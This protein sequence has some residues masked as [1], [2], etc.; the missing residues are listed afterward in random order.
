MRK[1]DSNKQSV[2]QKASKPAPIQSSP[3][4]VQMGFL[5]EFAENASASLPQ[6]LSASQV[7][8]L[9]RTLGNRTTTRLIQ[10]QR[11]R[12]SRNQP[13]S[14]PIRP[15]S[16][17]PPSVQRLVTR[18]NF[19]KLAGK[20][21][22]KA[23]KHEST[24]VKILKSLD[25]YHSDKE[26]WELEE[27]FDY[28]LKLIDKWYTKHTHKKGQKKGKLKD[29]SDDRKSMLLKTL[30][31][32]IEQE[33]GTFKD[34]S[35]A[36]GQG[37]QETASELIDKLEGAAIAS[38]R[39]LEK[40][41][42]I[43]DEDENDYRYMFTITA[44]TEHVDYLEFAKARMELTNKTKINPF[45]KYN[46]EAI[47]KEAAKQTVETK[48]SGM[49][50]EEKKT[51]IDELVNMR[52]QVGH[53]WVKLWVFDK[54]D[55][56][57]LEQDSFGFFP[58]VNFASPQMAFPG[59][60]RHP[61]KL[62]EG[63][64]G[65]DVEQRRLNQDI[66]GKGY[67]KAMNRATDLMKSPPDYKLIEYNCT[68]FAMDIAQAAGASFPENAYMRIPL[69]LG[70]ILNDNNNEDIAK[71]YSPNA[72]LEELK[73]D[74]RS[75]DPLNE[76]PQIKSEPEKEEIVVQASPGMGWWKANEDI[77]TKGE[78][79]TISS[80]DSFEI[81]TKTFDPTVSELMLQF[82]YVDVKYKGKSGTVSGLEVKKKATKVDNG[83]HSEVTEEVESSPSPQT[84]SV[85]N[86]SQRELV[87]EEGNI[88]EQSTTKNAKGMYVAKKDLAARGDVS[89]V[90]KGQQFE[91][92]DDTYFP[93]SPNLLL[94]FKYV[95]CVFEGKNCT[96]SGL[97]IKQS[98]SR[99]E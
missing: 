88:S 95:N 86:E 32:E 81:L 68:K 67:E 37:K 31:A 98:A 51:K 33:K 41:K 76:E 72:L 45:K 60:V 43:V 96:I 65:K 75:F 63:G 20:P 73:K 83:S 27:G 35:N 11:N 8:Q 78:T 58:L 18:T 48:Y 71:A 70:A 34:K 57:V 55:N 46:K 14:V 15:R 2:A 93:D 44:A 92:V 39:L 49:E 52:G 59:F 56:S 30:K 16:T 84:V 42:K 22:E 28:I 29:H 61:D 25:A 4:S 80:G 38:G 50:S 5:S 99:V 36:Y 9:Q 21:S 26:K 82:F 47:R 94:Q 77:E 97:L 69:T 64:G 91:V 85:Q 79:G 40:S 19:E 23:I 7:I 13:P 24:Y 53:T 1:S 3:T 90:K 62:H 54:D 87:E 6:K 89:E 74:E 10:R 66:T 17:R 12:A